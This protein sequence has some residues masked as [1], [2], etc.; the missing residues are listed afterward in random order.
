MF[1][2]G[3]SVSKI[4]IQQTLGD[5]SPVLKRLMQVSYS[6]RVHLLLWTP[7]LTRDLVLPR[8][9]CLLDP[10]CSLCTYLS[11]FLGLSPLWIRCRTMT[12]NISFVPFG[13]TH[14]LPC[15]TSIWRIGDTQH[16]YR[17]VMQPSG[18]VSHVLATRGQQRLFTPS[19]VLHCSKTTA[20]QSSKTIVNWW[21]QTLL[22]I[23][24]FTLHTYLQGQKIRCLNT[25]IFH[26]N[27]M[28]LSIEYDDET[29]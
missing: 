11:C 1:L 18:W 24:I 2:T 7:K 22:Q 10:F 15:Q 28:T 3:S 19:L 26:L 29:D 13:W 6:I 20:T 21:Q 17:N 5:S 8:F 9:T 27:V 4:Q 23:I 16:T 25:C 14:C 12:V